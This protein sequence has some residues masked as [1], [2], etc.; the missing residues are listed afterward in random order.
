MA[1]R[2]RIVV[3]TLDSQRYALPLAAVE[4]VVRAVAVTPVPQAAGEVLGVI[5]VEGHVTPV[6][7][8]RRRL[9]LP[10]RAVAV[11]D[12]FLLARSGARAVALW[13]DEVVGVEEC[14]EPDAEAVPPVVPE[15]AAV[16]G[17]VRRPDGLILVPDVD[18]LVSCLDLPSPAAAPAGTGAKP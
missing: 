14:A 9:G 7:D 17:V 2:M 15:E 10:D 1:D 8:V 6:I 11:S 16:R 13:I 4:R 18:R 3:F 5:D 12:E